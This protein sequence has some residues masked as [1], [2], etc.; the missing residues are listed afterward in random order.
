MAEDRQV[1]GECPDCG[2]EIEVEAGVGGSP[3]IVCG[4]C[5]RQFFATMA[6]A[7]AAFVEDESRFPAFIGGRGS[8][9][10]VSAVM[11]MF[12]YVNRWPGCRGMMTQPTLEMLETN[13]LPCIRDIFGDMEGRADGWSYLEKK[14]QLVFPSLGAKVFMRTAS[15]PNSLRGPTLAFG[16]MDEMGNDDQLEAFMI[17]QSAIRQPGYPN[18]LWGTTTPNVKRPWIKQVWQD[19]VNPVTGRPWKHPEQYVIHRASTSYNVYL[20]E[21]QRTELIEEYEGTRWGAQELGGEWIAVE[22][23]A[24]PE[25]TDAHMRRPPAGLVLKRRVVGLDLGGVE[26]T[27]LVLIGQDSGNRVWALEEF[28]ERG[29][30]DGSWISWCAERDVKKVLC[31]P[32]VAERDLRFWRNTSRVPIHRAKSKRFDTRVRLVGNRLEIGRDGLPGLYISPECPNLWDELLNLTYH[33][34]KGHPFARDQ[35][36]PGAVDHAY[37]ALG[38]ALMEIDGGRLGRPKAPVHVSRRAA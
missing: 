20:P 2:S 31:D 12:R 25:L 8:S 18:Q 30:K 24:F 36:T 34:P 1:V 6:G 17:L 10:T 28:Y 38:Y 37:D 5:G 33:K 21:W 3:R 14:K 15:E 16:S 11:K 23:S 29:A 22:G 19:K 26:P 35:W 27:A 7:Q 9:K 32:S 13:L 4:G